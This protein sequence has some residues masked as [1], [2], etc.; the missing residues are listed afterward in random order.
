MIEKII[1]FMMYLPKAIIEW[2]NVNDATVLLLTYFAFGLLAVETLIEIFVSNRLYS[3]KGLYKFSRGFMLSVF[4]FA[5]MFFVIL[6][7]DPAI[8]PYL[9][10]DMSADLELGVGQE[11]IVIIVTLFISWCALFFVSVFHDLLWFLHAGINM[12][13][14]GE[15]K[16]LRMIE[17]YNTPEHVSKSVVALVL[18]TLQRVFVMSALLLN[19]V[20][21]YYNFCM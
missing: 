8:R 18:T 7:C 13:T 21:L 6:L 15:S 5:P 12:L 2:L 14:K 10:S 16:T 17:G 11:L 4:K 20:A 1:D 9:P 19:T 3:R